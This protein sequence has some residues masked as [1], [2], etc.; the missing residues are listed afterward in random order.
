MRRL[1]PKAPVNGPWY[2]SSVSQVNAH[3]AGTIANDL[4]VLGLTAGDI[5]M[6]HSSLRR[7]GFVVGGPEAVVHALL[8]V[9]GPFGTVVVPTHVSDNSDPAQWLNPP[10][11]QEWWETIRTAQPAFD[12]ERTPSRW[13]GVI[14]ECVRTWPGS[15]RSE[16][17]QVSVA[18]VGR[19]AAYVT[20]THLLA[21]A[22]GDGSP[23]GR[24]Y[25]ADGRVLL[26]G[27]GHDSNTSLHLAETRQTDP[28]RTAYGA[29]VLQPDG[30]SRWVTWEDIDTDTSDFNDLGA[31]FEATGHVA[32]GRVGEATARLM[33][34]RALVDFGTQWLA[35]R[36]GRA[37]STPHR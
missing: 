26:L 16:H 29:A 31:A 14:A 19:R 34:Q 11:P 8:R 6:V 20:E 7:I 13:M 36:H 2:G 3:T 35:E 4:W 1:R 32:I 15:R 10:V 33:P 17:P 27:C 28:A 30:T 37:E 24:I 22:F 12:P 18:A 9:V 25:E 23:L 5:V 21:D